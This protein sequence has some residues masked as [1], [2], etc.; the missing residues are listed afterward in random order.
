ML[1]GGPIQKT[2]RVL[3]TLSSPLPL[4]LIKHSILK[5]YFTRKNTCASIMS[6]IYITL[7]KLMCWS[8]WS[9]VVSIFDVIILTINGYNYDDDTCIYLI[10]IVYI[11]LYNAVPI[12][13]DIT[14]CNLICNRIKT[15]KIVYQIT[16]YRSVKYDL[17]HSHDPKMFLSD[18]QRWQFVTKSELK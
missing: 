18:Y 3:G 16:P 7:V 9:K 15:N 14:Y 12:I 6:K 11:N 4:S 5:W 17:S 8:A 1:Q 10:K 2:A 13:V